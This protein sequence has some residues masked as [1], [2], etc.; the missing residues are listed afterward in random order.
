MRHGLA[1]FAFF[2]VG[3]LAVCA[4]IGS[5]GCSSCTEPTESTHFSV[6]VV[7]SRAIV[8]PG[9]VQQFFALVSGAPENE[10]TWSLIGTRP[11]GWITQSGLYRA[12]ESFPWPERRTRIVR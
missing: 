12:P 4:L 6:V 5:S 7:P 9:N 1:G 10:V 3:T 2:C 11:H 8:E